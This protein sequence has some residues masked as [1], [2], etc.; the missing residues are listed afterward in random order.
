MSKSLLFFALYSVVFFVTMNNTLPLIA[1]PY[2]VGELGGSNEIAFYTVTFYSLGNV[3]G[4]PIGKACVG[5]CA[6]APF[7]L[8]GL[9]CFALF[10][11]MTAYSGN[12]PTF[13]ATRVLEGIAAGSMFPMVASVFSVVLPKEKKDTNAM[14]IVTIFTVAPTFSA[15][16]GGWIS[17]D[18]EWKRLFFINAPLLLGVGVFLWRKLQGVQLNREKVPFDGVGYIFYILSLIPLSLVI[19]LG[20]QLDWYRSAIISA[21]TVIGALSLGFFILWELNHPFPILDFRLLKK[22]AF[23]LGLFMLGAIFSAYFGMVILL[24]YWLTLWVNYTPAWIAAITGGMAVA[25][26]LPSILFH[27]G[28]ECF[29]C[30]L[31]I[32]IALVFLAFSSF[33][34]TY[35][36]VEINFGRIAL[37]RI[38]AGFGLAF[39]LA[40][41]FRLCFHTYKEDKV[42]SVIGFFQLVRM[43][44]SGLGAAIF[45]TI[46]QRRQI[47]FHDRLGSQITAF[48]PT[49]QAYFAEAGQVNL[50]GPAANVE[51][52]SL[53]NR[54]AIA[55]ALDDCFYLI[56]WLMVALVVILLL[57]WACRCNGFKPEKQHQIL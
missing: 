44:A 35:F 20:Q 37:S 8:W 47:F 46:W 30:R 4:I 3:I 31:P 17:Y 9:F 28:Y 39:F 25:G 48:S 38:L 15:A 40:P 26:L 22:F 29:D 53:L 27:R 51:L 57:T 50:Q 36:N 42:L 18:Y 41:L 19:T 6:P 24:A 12:Y 49:T 34:T 5:R 32:L 52:D 21:L 1:A 54:Q 43:I 7:F 23:S 16:W 14:I 45:L 56:A 55:L 33:Y 13:L 11:F 2:I 10:S